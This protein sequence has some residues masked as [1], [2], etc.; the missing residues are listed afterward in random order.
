M[1]PP[2][3]RIGPPRRWN[4][5]IAGIPWLPRLIDKARAAD[6]GTLGFYLFGQSPVDRSL[7]RAM[8]MGYRSFFDIVVSAAD[9]DAVI[10]A[11][12]TRDRGA[13]G[14]GREWGRTLA[15]R[16]ALFVALLDIDDGYSAHLRPLRPAIALAANAVSWTAKRLWPLRIRVNLATVANQEAP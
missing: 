3:L 4:E 6:A 8:G 5:S 9:D 12:G 10:A 16:Q 1:H 2:D 15:R 11:I 13:L 7:L 14:R